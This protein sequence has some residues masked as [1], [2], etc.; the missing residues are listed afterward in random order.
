MQFRGAQGAQQVMVDASALFFDIFQETS[1][2]DFGI[3]PTVEGVEKGPLFRC[4]TYI[5]EKNAGFIG[6]VRSFGREL[7]RAVD[8]SELMPSKDY[9]KEKGYMNLVRDVEFSSFCKPIEESALANSGGVS[10]LMARHE[11]PMKPGFTTRMLLSGHT[12][13]IKRR[14]PYFLSERYMLDCDVESLAELLRFVYQGSSSFFGLRPRTDAEKEVLKHKMLRLCFKSETFSLDQLY[15]KVL[16][17]FGHASYQVIGE[18]NFADAFFHLQHFEL[19]CTEQHSRD[20]L[21]KTVTS[22]MLSTRE[23]FRS[24]TRDPRWASLPVD[25]VEGTLRYDLMP[26]SSEMEVLNLIERWNKNADKPKADL[27]R[28]LGC[29]RPDDETREHLAQWLSGMGWLQPGGG[30]IKDAALQE[31]MPELRAVHALL[32]GSACGRKKP[33]R[34][35]SGEAAEEAERELRQEK[36]EEEGSQHLGTNAQAE[37]GAFIHYQGPWEVARGFSFTLASGQRLVQIEPIRTAGIQRLRVVLSNSQ[38]I[39][40]DPNHEVF[41]GISY[42]ERRC[43]GYLC[44]ATAF[45]GIFSVRALAL[46]TVPEPS[47]AVHL[48]GSGN[49]VEF[50]CALE[51][52]LTRVNHVVTCK[53]SIIARNETLTEEHFQVSN[54]TLRG[55]SGGSQRLKAGSGDGLRYQVAASGLKRQE[56]VDVHLG[57]ASGGDAAPAVDEHQG[58][59]ADFE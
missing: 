29:F 9:F 43:F 10:A 45:S 13:A 18:R 48:T 27:I 59:L 16:H 52:Q 1:A 22:D 38:S 49:K 40:W 7:P 2:G 56:V 57:W 17:W 58:A 3:Q 26:I 14:D 47:A 21:V 55:L 42:G 31:S 36:E 46:G 44:S 23:Q 24:I 54:D 30:M 15:E 20:F 41:V 28:L 51:V 4:H 37:E 11:D 33:R 19:Q 50:D 53:L 34:N 8:T 5:L 12:S 6:K 35:L 32:D 39:L 25:F